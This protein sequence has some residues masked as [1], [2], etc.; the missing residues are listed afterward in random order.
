MKEP[1]RLFDCIEYNLER[2]P[3]D[4]MLAGKESGQ[5]KKYSTATVQEIVNKLAAG[6]MALGI[7]P[8]DM[9]LERLR[10][11]HRG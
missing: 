3:L 1:R 5:W 6:L 2:N 4:D 8:N 10:H 11:E 7:G 9:T